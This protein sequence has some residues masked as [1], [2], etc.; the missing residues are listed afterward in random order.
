MTA[1]LTLVVVLTLGFFAALVDSVLA[2]VVGG[3]A[4]V[5]VAMVCALGFGV[6]LLTMLD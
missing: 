6:S 1:R 4:E 3:W 5:G 2:G